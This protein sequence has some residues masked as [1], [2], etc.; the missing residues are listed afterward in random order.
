MKYTKLIVLILVTFQFSSCSKKNLSKLEQVT[1][2]YVMPELT[3]TINLNYKIDKKAINDTFNIIIDQYLDTDLEM[4]AMGMD[5]KVTKQQDATM[6]FSGT[7]VLSTLP[8]KIEIEKSTFL[9]NITGQGQLELK[10]ITGIDIDSNWTLITNTELATHEWIEK[11]K[12]SLGGIQ[13][14]VGMLADEIIK[15]S[16]PTLEK[17][18][19]LSVADQI[20]FKDRLLDMLK[21]VEEP[22]L[23]DTLMNSWLSIDPHQVSMSHIENGAEFATGNVSVIG[24]T[25]FSSIKP[26]KIAGIKLPQFQWEP[27]VDDTSHLNIILDISYD[28]VNQYLT[29]NY[30]GETL[31]NGGKEVTIHNVFL[32]REGD[33][34][35]VVSDVTGSFNGKLLVSGTPVFDNEKQEFYTED[36]DID[37]ETK[38]VIHKAGAWFFKGKIKNKL[39]NMLNFSVHENLDQLQEMINQQIS[40]YSVKNEIEFKADLKKLQ[41]E[42]FVIDDDKLHAFVKFDIF[43][44]SKIYNLNAFNNPTYFKLKN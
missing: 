36:I 41:I 14:N 29:D 1:P 23:I 33:K 21:Y 15:R 6:E 7:Q 8:I 25:N 20:S 5:V 37:I 19:D 17:Q 12:L 18:I 27:T 2:S 39:K 43:L 11:P 10:F 9:K 16:K 24:K 22:I 4:D 35:I 3:S 40:M 34:L 30:K 31:K 28:Q 26:E 42:K 44:Q 38:N 13:F 32:K